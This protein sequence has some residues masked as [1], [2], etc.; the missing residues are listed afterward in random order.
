MERKEERGERKARVRS[1]MAIYIPC[2]FGD[3]LIATKT[4]KHSGDLRCF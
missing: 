3:S 2:R 4:T 1:R